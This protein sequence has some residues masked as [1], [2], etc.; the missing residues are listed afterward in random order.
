[1]ADCP[2]LVRGAMVAPTPTILRIID[3]RQVKAEAHVVKR[4]AFQLTT[5]EA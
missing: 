4:R 1:M 5:E 2:R 3:G